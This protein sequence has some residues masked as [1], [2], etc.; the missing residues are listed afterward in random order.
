MS[1]TIETLDGLEVPG[2]KIASYNTYQISPFGGPVIV[3]MMV[4]TDKIGSAVEK[5][6]KRSFDTLQDARRFMETVINPPRE[7][8]GGLITYS[9]D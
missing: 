5:Q 7:I 2:E 6:V 3:K 1:R 8:K 4:M 9:K